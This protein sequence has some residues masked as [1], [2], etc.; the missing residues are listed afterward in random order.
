MKT[1]V[2]E[3][4]VVLDVIGGKWKPLLVYHLGEE[5]TKRFGELRS[6][7]PNVSHKTL[8][9][10]LKELEADGIITRTAYAC[11]PPRVEYAITEKGRT[12]LPI[13]EM[14]CDWG[15][16]NLGEHYIMT[17]PVCTGEE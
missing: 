4:E 16:E 13:L 11:V 8:I 5:G 9:N 3:I 12:L 2:C 15:F 14:M 17:N 1:I 10:Q 6:Y 7:I